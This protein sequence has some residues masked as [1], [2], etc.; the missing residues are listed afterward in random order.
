[1]S[2]ERS[3]FL[4]ELGNRISIEV[5][6]TMPDTDLVCTECRCRA[7]HDPECAK[8]SEPWPEMDVPDDGVRIA[9]TGP[10][11]R[12]ENFLTRREAE[13]LRDLLIVALPI[14]DPV[15]ESKDG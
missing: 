3:N 15:K 11:S 1:M 5:G 4:N 10:A 13:V 6:T 14:T 8:A 7:G 9:I 2:I 12:N